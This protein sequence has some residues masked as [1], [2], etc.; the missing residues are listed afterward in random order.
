MAQNT[1]DLCEEEAS[2]E[3]DRE[4][5]F[6]KEYTPRFRHY[7]VEHAVSALDGLDD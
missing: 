1:C 3:F 4:A 7:C 6:G 2:V 5:H